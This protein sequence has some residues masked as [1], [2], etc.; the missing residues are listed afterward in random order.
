M[1]AQLMDYVM[2]VYRLPCSM[3]QLIC[4]HDERQSGYDCQPIETY[5]VHQYFVHRVHRIPVFWWLHLLVA[6]VHVLGFPLEPVHLHRRIEY[7]VFTQNA[8]FDWPTH[9]CVRFDWQFTVHVH[10]QAHYPCLHAQSVHTRTY[11]RIK[12]NNVSHIDF[13][14]YAMCNSIQREI[15]QTLNTFVI[16]IGVFKSLPPTSRM[17]QGSRSSSRSRSIKISRGFEAIALESRWK[18]LHRFPFFL[19]FD[20]NLSLITRTNTL[21]NNISCTQFQCD[22]K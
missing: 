12:C 3:L 7:L 5:F 20:R 1:V 15:I 4:C 6:E 18:K 19:R 13:F 17:P 21:R 10:S 9:I 11:A 16:I 22:F 2:A 8:L 14:F